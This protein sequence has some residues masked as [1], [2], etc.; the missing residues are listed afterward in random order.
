MNDLM[1]FRDTILGMAGIGLERW[2]WGIPIILAVIAVADTA[3]EFKHL[4]RL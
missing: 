3:W 1:Q 2:V 4:R